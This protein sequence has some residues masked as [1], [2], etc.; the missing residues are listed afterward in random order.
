MKERKNLFDTEVNHLLQYNI[1]LQMIPFELFIV[2]LTFSPQ[3]C[4]NPASI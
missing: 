2:T 4:M 1:A 3:I